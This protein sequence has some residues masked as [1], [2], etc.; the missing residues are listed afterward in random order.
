MKK[1]DIENRLKSAG[2]KKTKH[3]IAIMSALAVQKFPISA[4]KIKQITKNLQIDEATIYR[5]LNKLVETGLIIQLNFNETAKLYELENHDHHHHI[6]CTNCGKVED[7]HG[8]ILETL[9]EKAL[10]ETDFKEIKTHTMELY[11]LC[12]RCSDK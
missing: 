7:I 9:T 2:L 5:I 8:C 3:R 11:G 6:I 1:I 12:A 4:Q 10:Q